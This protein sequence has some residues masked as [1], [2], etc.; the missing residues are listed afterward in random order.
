MTVNKLETAV[1]SKLQQRVWVSS[2]ILL[3]R[4][5]PSLLAYLF[6]GGRLFFYKG[7]DYFCCGMNHI[8]SEPQLRRKTL[9]I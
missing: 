2:L 3:P 7:D 8:S 5:C 4:P 1:C 6:L 9:G